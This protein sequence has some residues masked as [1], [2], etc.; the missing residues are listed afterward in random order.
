MSNFLYVPDYGSDISSDKKLE[1]IRSIIHPLDKIIT[2]DTQG[3]YTPYAYSCGLK[4]VIEE[5]INF[6]AIIGS[7]L[8]GFWATHYATE[9]FH[10]V[11]F[12]VFNPVMDPKKQLI[13]IDHVTAKSYADVEEINEELSIVPAL[14]IVASDDPVIPSGPTIDFF[15]YRARVIVVES[16]DHTLDTDVDKYNKILS[17]FLIKDINRLAV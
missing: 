6:D 4:K 2:I 11:P 13:P 8:G 7:S 5:D 17:N 15:S 1:L 12:V 9:I 16:D 14:V 10:E 3:S